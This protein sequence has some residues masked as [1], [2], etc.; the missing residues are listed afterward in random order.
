MEGKK[1]KKSITRYNYD[2][3]AQV[4][5]LF[6]LDYTSRCGSARYLQSKVRFIKINIM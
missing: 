1:L 3:T 6:S 2:L 5:F 4:L